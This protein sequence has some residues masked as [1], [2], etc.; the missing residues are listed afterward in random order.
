MKVAKLM[1]GVPS[2]PMALVAFVFASLPYI[3]PI[4]E[5]DIHRLAK[6]E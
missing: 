5:L 1:L 3:G 6:N 2:T 4:Y